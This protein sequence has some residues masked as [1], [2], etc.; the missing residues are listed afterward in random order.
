MS[1]L[2][3]AIWVGLMRVV[4]VNV[5]SWWQPAD[6]IISNGMD[7]QPTKKH[8][9]ADKR[10]NQV[11]EWRM[12][13]RAKYDDR[14]SN[15]CC[16]PEQCRYAK[17]ATISNRAADG[18]NVEHSTKARNRFTGRKEKRHKQQAEDRCGRKRYGV[19][20]PNRSSCWL[21]GSVEVSVFS[22]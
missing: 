8:H 20:V 21:R 13:H 4:G 17:G 14:Q 12:L 3:A 11:R 15:K 10:N 2:S 7:S 1:L 9:H 16:Y 18:A 6:P 5:D 19:S 22:A